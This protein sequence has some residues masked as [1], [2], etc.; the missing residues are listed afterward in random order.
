MDARLKFIFKFDKAQLDRRRGW[1]RGFLSKNVRG[2]RKEKY[3][4]RQNFNLF[5]YIKIKYQARHGLTERPLSI[6]KPAVQF[7]LHHEL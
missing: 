1:I 7:V 4:T 6:G 5:A 2:L 3:F